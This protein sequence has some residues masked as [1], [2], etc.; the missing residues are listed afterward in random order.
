MN[1]V[2]KVLEL[3]GKEKDEK[4]I[5]VTHIT[6]RQSIFF[7]VLKLFALELF[8][9]LFVIAFHLFIVSS[10]VLD[11]VSADINLLNTPL[12]IVLVV[13]KT[14]FMIYIIVAWL[15]E[16]YEITPKEI[17]HRK[18]YIIRKERR[19]TLDHIGT[20]KIEQSVL[21]SIFNY[22]T[23]RLYDW[24]KDDYVYLYLIHNPLKY[25]K[26][27]KTLLPEVDVEERLLRPRIIDK[28]E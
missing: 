14:A 11:R 24:V 16:F 25:S 27:L 19:F 9:A 2:E 21:G 5:V 22:G 7:L 28:E 13:L 3:E 6:I 20:L 23:I 17:L 18:G 1:T 15:E 12:F 26:I 10:S 4:R 8:A